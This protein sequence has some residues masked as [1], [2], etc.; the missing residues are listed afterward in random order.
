MN[1]H[2]A[3]FDL[4]LNLG[5]VQGSILGALEYAVALFDESTMQRYVGDF[6]ACCRPWSLTTRRCW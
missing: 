1:S 2:F 6:T 5:E 4:S 3:K